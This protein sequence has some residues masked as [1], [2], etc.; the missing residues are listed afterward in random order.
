MTLDRF[1]ARD[2]PDDPPLTPDTFLAGLQSLRYYPEYIT[3]IE[4]S[5]SPQGIIMSDVA[6]N[7]PRHNQVA[8]VYYPER[9]G[10]RFQISMHLPNNQDSAWFKE[11]RIALEDYWNELVPDIDDIHLRPVYYHRERAL[12]LMAIEPAKDYLQ[13]AIPDFVLDFVRYHPQID[14]LMQAVDPF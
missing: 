11:N 6:L 10:D 7:F 14:I 1:E 5:I 9:E 8:V 4:Y 13:S 12:Y 2:S 3:S